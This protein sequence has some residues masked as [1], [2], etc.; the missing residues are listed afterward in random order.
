MRI[1]G[2]WRVCDDGVVRPVIVGEIKA[3]DGSWVDVPFLVDSAADRTVLSAG[4]ASTIQTPV[5][6]LYS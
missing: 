1:D 3:P 2:A 6:R 4:A 5:E